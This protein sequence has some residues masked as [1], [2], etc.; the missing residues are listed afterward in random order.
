MAPSGEWTLCPEKRSAARLKLFCF[1]HAGVGSS[2]FRGWA[3]GLNADVEVSLVQLPGRE[4]RLREA[5]IS[6]MS[7][8]VPALIKELLPLLD[9]PFAFYGHSLGATVAFEAAL[10]LRQVLNIEPVHLFVGASP[11]PHLPWNHPPLRSSPEDYF[12]S[13][14]ERR[15]GALPHEVM[16]DDEMRALVLPILRSDV[17][18]LET[19][20][21]TPGKPLDCDITAFGGL[22]DQ[23][24]P[25]RA[26][27]AWRHQTSGRFRLQMLDGNHFFLRSCRPQLLEFI[28]EALQLKRLQSV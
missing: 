17:A 4:G 13:E 23:I 16:S 27:E 8:L 25:R 9:R 20:T 6:S 14:I 15:Y 3:G 2:V 18:M 11:A 28:A 1:H 26:L 7:A 22:R 10:Q 21:C 12:L 24:V 19:Y 5:L